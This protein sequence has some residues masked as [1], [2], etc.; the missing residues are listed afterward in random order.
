[1]SD[2]SIE[3]F[4]TILSDSLKNIKQEYYRIETNGDKFGIPRER[5]F[6]Y[7][8]YHQLRCE[9]DDDILRIHGELDKRGQNDFQG[10]TRAIPD[11]LIHQPGTHRN[12]NIIIEVKGVLNK[13]DLIGDLQKIYSFIHDPTIHYENGIFLQYNYS[14]L[15]LKNYLSSRI[16]EIKK[17]QDK[18]IV[19]ICS[20]KEGIVEI[21]TLA[22]LRVSL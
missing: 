3:S 19:I 7:E 10:K 15:D 13:D 6:C 11:F 14:F 9:F 18:K 12:N 2:F 1:M 21:Y 20:K 16:N 8:L 4:L 5:V 22:A 17:D